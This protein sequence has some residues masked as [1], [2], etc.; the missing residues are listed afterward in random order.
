MGEPADEPLRLVG[1][2]PAGGQGVD[3]YVFIGPIGG[4]VFGER[5]AML[6]H[7]TRYCFYRLPLC[8]QCRV[9]KLNTVSGFT[10]KKKTPGLIA[11]NF[12]GRSKS[13]SIKPAFFRRDSQV[14]RLKFHCFCSIG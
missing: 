9:E 2:N 11:P 3:P 5:K 13:H 8:L 10:P 12:R 7:G 1:E 6:D 4:Q 14:T